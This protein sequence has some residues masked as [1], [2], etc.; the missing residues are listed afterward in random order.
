VAIVGG[1]IA[2][3]RL[4]GCLCSKGREAE[5]EKL[6]DRHLNNNVSEAHRT[7]KCEID[8][9]ESGGEDF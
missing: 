9:L 4:R 8:Q 3:G 2:G 6:E 1:G 7:K 5:S